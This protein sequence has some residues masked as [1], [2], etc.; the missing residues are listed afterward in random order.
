MGP[1]VQQRLKQ[2]SVLSPMLTRCYRQHCCVGGGPACA[3]PLVWL[4]RYLS[5]GGLTKSWE[6]AALSHLLLDMHGLSQKGICIPFQSHSICL[7]FALSHDVYLAKA[8]PAPLFYQVE[9]L[10]AQI[11]CRCA[12]LRWSS[13]WEVNLGN[14]FFSFSCTQWLVVMVGSWSAE[15][16]S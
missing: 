13:C 14:S 2:P 3:Q 8:L 16:A 4:C 9:S 15:A 10:S 6:E 1:L 5:W 12:G 11:R 7:C